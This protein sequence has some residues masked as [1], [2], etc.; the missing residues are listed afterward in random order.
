MSGIETEMFFSH[1]TNIYVQNAC[2]FR[3]LSLG[4]DWLHYIQSAYY[5]FPILKN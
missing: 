4:N 5:H 2:L 3:S 1:I